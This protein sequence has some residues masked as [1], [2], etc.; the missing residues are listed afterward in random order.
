MN[1]PLLGA[2]CSMMKKIRG[3]WFQEMVVFFFFCLCFEEKIL[4]AIMPLER[5]GKEG[6]ENEKGN[7][8][9]GMFFFVKVSD[10]D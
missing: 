9:W 4:D 3:T 10:G 8:L 1:A 5:G 2:I 7:Y 6:G